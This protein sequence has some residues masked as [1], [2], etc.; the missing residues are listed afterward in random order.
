MDLPCVEWQKHVEQKWSR[1][2]LDEKKC[3]SSLL[4]IDEVFDFGL[5]Q[6]IQED[7]D[8]LSGISKDDPVQKDLERAARCRKEGNSSFKTRDYTAAV[9]HYSQGVC[10]ASL[11][12]EQLSLCYA[13]RSAA[14]FHLQRYRECL[15]DIDR[16][17]NHGYPSHLKHKLQD[18]QAQCLNH[19]PNGT[20]GITTT[21]QGAGHQAEGVCSRTNS[22]KPNPKSPNSQQ[23]NGSAS[24][25]CL[26]P[27]LSVCFSPE[28]GRHLVAT[29][30]IAAG[31][32]ILENRAY[33]CV[34]IPG[35]GGGRREETEEA[36]RVFGTE[37]RYCH[38]C[39]RE[40]VSPVPCE[41]CSYA[42]Y[43]S[44]GCRRG[45]WE[46]HHRWECP[47]GAEL[48]TAGVM[49]QL[50]L[51]VAL[52]AGVKE[53]LK[54]REPIRDADNDSKLIREK[55]SANNSS[56]K[57]ITEKIRPKMKNSGSSD[58]TSTEPEVNDPSAYYHGDSYL[59]VYH[60]LPHLNGHAPSL[61][62]LCSVTIATLY[63]RL[64]QAGPPP[65]SWERGGASESM[66]CSNQS[67]A[68]EDGEG[69]APEL[70]LLGSVAL[71]H[72]LQLR[73]NAQAVSLLRDTGDFT[74]V[75]STQEVRIATAIFPTLSILN[76]SCC[77]NTSLNFRTSHL[78][79]PQPDRGSTDVLV[80]T[81]P[82]S[83]GPE[84]CSAPV[85]VSAGVAVSIRASRDI[86]PGQE[87][88]HCYGPHSSRMVLCER[89]RLLQE[90]Y[91]FLCICQACSLEQGEGPEGG[92]A[93]PETHLQCG[94]CEGPV[95]Q[96]SVDSAGWFVCVRLSCGH[97]V[98]R[99]EMDLRLQEVRVQ[100]EQAV[101]LLETDRPA[102]SV[103]LLQRAVSHAGVFLKETHS[104]QGQLADTM[105]RAYST[106]GEWR[107]AACQLER[108][109]LA[110]R[111][112]YGQDSIELGRQ[113]FKLAQLHFNGGSPG[114]ALSVI[115]R[116]RRLLSLH[117][118]P[119]CP[120]VQELQSMEDCLQGVL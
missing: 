27:G 74:A 39:L 103:M 96:C 47:I 84:A 87:V 95:K 49:S 54:A 116:A 51:R 20:E 53:V 64:R 22:T 72:M 60:L 30:G 59:S 99:S 19:F 21:K 24:V 68:P 73:C 8:F 57:P 62:F 105:A 88:L 52:K 63:L 18:R 25:S 38:Q 109:V 23:Q 108:S 101:D 97:R 106:M 113:L 89:R 15:E 92:G 4:D 91:H 66:T 5:S 81:E 65:V 1:L 9:L 112:Q 41:G 32:V 115:S 104:L 26:S 55:I 13:N 28:K 3:F 43:C 120:E 111:S 83:T 77:P 7:V 6:V 17:L 56:S 100:L 80:S 70:S 69:W 71:R 16:A 11:S 45:A 37:V 34:L 110:I 31:E 29:K 67:R 42:R 78:V 107:E 94:K 12:S 36:G 10:H 75:Q 33:S 46:W 14:L 61:R 86:C 58:A 40:T 119:H 85:S 118:G 102:Q 98:S 117:C 90:Q 48:S 82:V 114:P 50:A 35:M 2:T 76:H 44:E 93:G 79:S